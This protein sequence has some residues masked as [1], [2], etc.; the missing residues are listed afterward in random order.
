MIGYIIA[1]AIGY[2]LYAAGYK[3][4]LFWIVVIVGANGLLGLLM[5]LFNPHWYQSRRVQ[6]GLDIDLLNPRAGMGGLIAVKAITTGA[7][8][9][10]AYWLGR[11]IGLV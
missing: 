2:G 9:M 8:A 11:E 1:V 6:A 5:A 7:L 10:V 4:L 3:T